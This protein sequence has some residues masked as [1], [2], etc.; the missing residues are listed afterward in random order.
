MGNWQVQSDPVKGA[1]TLNQG[2]TGMMFFM[3]RE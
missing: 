2:R 1:A 3:T